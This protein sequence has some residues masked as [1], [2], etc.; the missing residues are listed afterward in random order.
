VFVAEPAVLPT[1]P[2][3]EPAALPTVFVVEP[4]VLPTVFVAESAVLFTVWMAEPAVLSTVS[5]AEGAVLATASVADPAVIVVA[6]VAE[7][8]APAIGHGDWG[9]EQPERE[10]SGKQD[11][12]YPERTDTSVLKP[13]VIM[14]FLHRSTPLLSRHNLVTRVPK[15]KTAGWETHACRG[16][17]LRRAT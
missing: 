13:W 16:L 6:S 2:V 3:A 5:E 17:E 11:K 14:D 7:P 9:G 1:V 15:P 8:A 12:E 4:T 10:N